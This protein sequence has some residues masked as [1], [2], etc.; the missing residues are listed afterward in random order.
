MTWGKLDCERGRLRWRPMTEKK[1]N[2]N[3]LQ[4]DVVTADTRTPPGLDREAKHQY[5][6]YSMSKYSQHW[7]KRLIWNSSPDHEFWTRVMVVGRTVDGSK[8]AAE[9]QKD[10][11]WRENETKNKVRYNV[12]Q[13]EHYNSS[14]YRT[15][16]LR[17]ES[18]RNAENALN[19]ITSF[20]SVCSVDCW[21][22]CTLDCQWGMSGDQ[23]EFRDV[24]FLR[25]RVC[26]DGLKGDGKG[27]D[28][29][30]EETQMNSVGITSKPRELKSSK[31]KNLEIPENRKWFTHPVPPTYFIWLFG[32]QG[33]G[34]MFGPSDLG[35]RDYRSKKIR[36]SK[37]REMTETT[38]LMSFLLF[39]PTVK[40]NTP[41]QRFW[42]L[43]NCDWPISAFTRGH[44]GCIQLFFLGLVHANHGPKIARAHDCPGR[45]DDASARVSRSLNKF[46]W[47]GPWLTDLVCVLDA[48]VPWHSPLRS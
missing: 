24:L 16:L 15:A 42:T 14:S 48:T 33:I 47:G 39:W 31:W 26:K 11:L 5:N 38:L 21:C 3:Y 28:K 41:G 44:C 12:I 30:D 40:E 9:L 2:E 1:M 45:L 8:S 43:E 17:P 10:I 22:R 19:D 36:S 29:G 20:H 4:G 34:S 27:R 37:F 23:D 25:E 18:K 32:H 46:L 7:P 6:R 13:Q 35:I